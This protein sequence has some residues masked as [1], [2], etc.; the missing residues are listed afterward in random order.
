MC[1]STYLFNGYSFSH[2]QKYVK[3]LC[4]YINVHVFVDMYNTYNTLCF[5][6]GLSIPFHTKHVLTDN[7]VAIL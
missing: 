5:T 3:F 2:L 6:K 7:L 4:V 1:V